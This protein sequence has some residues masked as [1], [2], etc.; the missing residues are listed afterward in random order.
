MLEGNVVALVFST[1][2]MNEQS[3]MGGV[4]GIMV[5]TQALVWLADGVI[6]LI[7]HST[8]LADMKHETWGRLESTRI[9]SQLPDSS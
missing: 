4:E 6:E 3:A 1:P 8:L 5:M 7:S 9:L 2:R